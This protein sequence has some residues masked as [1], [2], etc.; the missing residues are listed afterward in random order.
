MNKAMLLCDLWDKLPV[1]VGDVD[2]LIDYLASMVVVAR[3]ASG[4]N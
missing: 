4:C 1:S 3:V 2:A